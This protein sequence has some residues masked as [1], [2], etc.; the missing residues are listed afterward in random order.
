MCFI[1]LSGIG[2]VT[3]SYYV[4]IDVS[5]DMLD[6]CV[7][8][9]GEFFRLSNDEAGISKLRKKLQPL[10]PERVVM[11]ATGGYEAEA[12]LILRVAGMNVCVVNPLRVRNFAKADGQL[13]K[14]DRIDA[15]VIAKFGER[16]LPEVRE[17]ASEAVRD[18]DA[19][20][21]RR[22]QLVQMITSEKNR[23]GISARALRPGI[24]T[25]IDWMN[26]EV[27]RIETDLDQAIQATAGWQ[28]KVELYTS[29]PGIGPKTAYS[30]IAEVPEL[31]RISAKQIS[32]LVGVAPYPR[33]SGVFKGT[34]R[35]RGGRI[36][37]RC[38]L[39]M[40]T[41]SAIRCNPVIKAHYTQLRA[42]GKV[43]KVA[44]VACMRKLLVI[45]SAMARSKTP[46]DSG[47]AA[48]A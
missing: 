17:I 40:A 28:E 29:A 45:L 18:L 13:A 35:I 20:V 24:Q 16:M 1:N 5:K 12:V 19:L 43:F 30:L 6:V 44:M 38:M 11:E 41:L 47:F 10:S 39:Y 25:H 33:E 31:D 42:R 32:A 4:G 7:L 27:G 15:G 9:T 8:P 46:W 3:T 36:S 26:G 34:R 14:T 22:R 37:V 21:T 23:L 48:A 2:W